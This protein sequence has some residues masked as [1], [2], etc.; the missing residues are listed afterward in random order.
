[1]GQDRKEEE[2]KDKEEN[3]YAVECDLKGNRSR[4]GHCIGDDKDQDGSALSIKKNIYPLE[5]EK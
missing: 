3:R 4:C 2:S 5:K 1:M